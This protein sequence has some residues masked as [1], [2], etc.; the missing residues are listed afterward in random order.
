M[1]RD[2]TSLLPIELEF[3]L[4]N[5][6]DVIRLIFESRIEVLR[7]IIDEIFCFL[8]H[9]IFLLSMPNISSNS[10]TVSSPDIVGVLVGVFGHQSLCSRPETSRTKHFSQYLSIELS[11]PNMFARVPIPSP[12]L[13]DRPHGKL[14]IVCRI[15]DIFREE[16]LAPVPLPIESPRPDN[17]L[18]ASGRGTVII[19]D[20]GLVARFRIDHFVEETLVDSVARGVY[21][22]RTVAINNRIFGRGGYLRRCGLRPLLGFSMRNSRNR[23]VGRL[24]GQAGCRLG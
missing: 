18:E 23:S 6:L 3:R 24:F 4:L 7:E 12:I 11:I 17:E 19:F 14:R 8:V 16:L 9:T 2:D 21:F 5:L 1:L 20:T 10:F 22:R 13:R 15:V